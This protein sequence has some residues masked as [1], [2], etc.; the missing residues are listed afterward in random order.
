M[1]EADELPRRRRSQER[2]AQLGD[3]RVAQPEIGEKRDQRTPR[4]SGWNRLASENGQRE[5][6]PRKFFLKGPGD[7]LERYR[8]R[9]PRLAGENGASRV[10]QLSQARLEGDLA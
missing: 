5:G 6:A 7:C 2:R 4:F 1:G 9:C 10:G 8:G 3:V